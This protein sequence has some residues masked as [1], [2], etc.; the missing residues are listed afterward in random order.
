MN[1]KKIKDKTVSDYNP[2]YQS[3]LNLE[4]NYSTYNISNDTRLDNKYSDAN[5]YNK[6]S[7]LYNSNT[8]DYSG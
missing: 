5:I 8:Y 7:A 2:G 4:N 6:N 1:F 3:N